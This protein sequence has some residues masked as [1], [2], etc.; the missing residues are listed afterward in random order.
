MNRNGDNPA[1]AVRVM[2]R[3]PPHG[4]DTNVDVQNDKNM[5]R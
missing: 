5:K 4:V 1:P 3:Q 2:R